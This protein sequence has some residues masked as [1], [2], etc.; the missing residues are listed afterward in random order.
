M[1]RSLQ[2]HKRRQLLIRTHNETLF[3][4]AMG[5]NNLQYSASVG[6]HRSRYNRFWV[7]AGMTR[8]LRHRRILHALRRT[9]LCDW[10][11]SAVN[12]NFSCYEKLDHLHFGPLFSGDD[13]GFVQ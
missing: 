7:R 5:F 1:Y 11:S 9:A 12:D 4:A 10:M 8:R 6:A 13:A 3:V 2:F